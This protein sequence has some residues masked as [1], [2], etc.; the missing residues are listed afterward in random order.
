MSTFVDHNPINPSVDVNTQLPP[1][2]RTLLHTAILAVDVELVRNLI[3]RGAS[4]LLKDYQNLTPLGLC[5]SMFAYI[6]P[7]STLGQKLLEIKDILQEEQLSTMGPPKPLMQRSL[8]LP[9]AKK[10][11]MALLSKEDLAIPPLALS[12]LQRSLSRGISDGNGLPPPM[13]KRRSSDRGTQDPTD[14]IMSGRQIFTP[15]TLL[16]LTSEGHYVRKEGPDY[17]SGKADEEGDEGEFDDDDDA[18]HLPQFIA[19]MS[20]QYQDL[21]GEAEQKET[22]PA[23]EEGGE[24]EP[25]ERETTFHCDICLESL[26]FDKL[27]PFCPK[28]DCNSR[29]CSGCV[30]QFVC[31]VIET[32]RYA[33]PPMR[34]PSC[35]T[36]IPT[37]SWRRALLEDDLFEKYAKNAESILSVRCPSCDVLY[38]EFVKNS[39]VVKDFEERVKLTEEIFDGFSDELKVRVK[40]AWKRFQKEYI[41]S[42]QFVVALVDAFTEHAPDQR[43]TEANRPHTMLSSR[44][45]S[46]LRLILDMERRV[47]LQ[48]S[49]YRMFPFIHM[50]CPNS[51]M[52]EFCFMCKVGFWHSG[53]TCTE[54]QQSEMEIEAQFCPGCGVPTVRSEGCTHIVCV[55]GTEWY[56][57]GD[58]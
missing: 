9:E 30:E 18:E 19:S 8:S 25:A 11:P 57:E 49:F 10:D 4:L 34:C 20:Q 28:E 27:Q 45:R 51:C 16:R 42:D 26:P 52:S 1:W 58:Y 12:L 14:A 21:E 35:F 39:E 23:D 17:L 41:T 54:R 55:C 31:N 44:F 7:E 24:G 15:L 46:I 6:D 2:Q 22:E 43:P 36:R 38:S 50:S 56:W 48:L 37:P 5:K 33:V 47:A 53:Q 3:D 40:K 13:L 32:T 29:V